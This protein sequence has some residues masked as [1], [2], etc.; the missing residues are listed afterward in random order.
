MSNYQLG[1]YEKSMPGDLT[2]A[3][4]LQAARNAG[5]DY[6]EMS[7]DE[8]DAKL[9]R[10][11]MTDGEIDAVRAAMRA[12]GVPFRSICLSGHRKFPLGCPD[13]QKQD[14]SLEIMQKAIALAA[15]LGIRT[16]QLAG[17]DV[18]YEEGTD[19]TRADFLQ[20]LRKAADM[21]AAEG[22]QMGFETMETPFMD[23]VE[24]AMDYVRQV[25]SPY[26]GVYPD[27]GNITN[28]AL[29][30][31]GDVA[32]DLETGRGHIVAVH[33]K[34]TVPG[35]YREIPFGTG[36]VDFQKIV[37]KSWQLG[38][39]RFVGEFWYDPQTDWREELQKANDFLRSYL[40]KAE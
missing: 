24:K 2:W 7:I 40:D 28:A 12:T 22:I 17:Y 13:K 34:E 27:S 32:D 10:L 25:D 36:H 9:A 30:Y 4:K 14:R 23:T 31:D 35:K 18:Y 3:E 26:L 5:F 21:A 33:L 37:D 38:V 11:D 39:R 1:L 8:T 15:K 20:N 19:K 29:L 6:V 16:I